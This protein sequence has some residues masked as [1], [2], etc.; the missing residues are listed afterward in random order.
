MSVKLGITSTRGDRRPPA[1]LAC[2]LAA[3]SFVTAK[4]FVVTLLTHTVQAALRSYLELL[5]DG[6]DIVTRLNQRLVQSV[7][8]G[9]FMSLI[10]AIVDPAARTIEYVNAGH[11]G[12]VVCQR[13]GV[14]VLEKT[15]MVLGVVGD[16]V[17]EA[18][19]PV[20]FEPDD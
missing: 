4:F 2:T 3:R 12:L 7:E 1:S 10:L 11:P 19:P 5:D 15:G 14:Q 9:N 16:Q 20:A 18:R 6:G 17:Y 8:T 13:G